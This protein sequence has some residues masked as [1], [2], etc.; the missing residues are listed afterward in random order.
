MSNN[1]K[2]IGNTIIVIEVKENGFLG[3]DKKHQFK[4][5]K[6]VSYGELVNSINV[7]D[8]I[9]VHTSSV[10]EFMDNLLITEDNKVVSVVSNGN[11]QENVM[12]D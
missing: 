3:S 10:S 5:Y 2:A 1:H 12:L 8:I 9:T 7:G 11:L 4:K 6:V